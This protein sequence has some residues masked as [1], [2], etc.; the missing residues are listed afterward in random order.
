MYVNKIEAGRG[1]PM[2]QQARLDV[3]G[4]WG[5]VSSGLS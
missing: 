1:A 4:W 2:A 5:P 3:S